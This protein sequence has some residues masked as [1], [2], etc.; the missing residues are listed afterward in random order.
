MALEEG[1]LWIPAGRW[2]LGCYRSSVAFS[3]HVWPSPRPICSLQKVSYSDCS[4]W[5][6]QRCLVPCIPSSLTLAP[7]LHGPWGAKSSAPLPCW[8]SWWAGL[9]AIA[10]WGSR[11][12]AQP[13]ENSPAAQPW[14]QNC[15]KQHWEWETRGLTI[16]HRQTVFFWLGFT[17]LCK[18]HITCLTLSSGSR[19]VLKECCQDDD[20]CS[21][22]RYFR[23]DWR[24]LSICWGS[25][26]GIRERPCVNLFL[27]KITLISITPVNLASKQCISGLCFCVSKHRIRCLCAGAWPQLNSQKT[28]RLIHFTRSTSSENTVQLGSGGCGRQP[29]EVRVL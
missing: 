7:I 22:L 11:V 17:L 29:G 13:H 6:L 20:A 12:E 10:S 8:K 14:V 21:F 25:C 2:S 27:I 24:A 28:N 3:G 26:L 5:V 16:E 19:L 4:L 18:F 23:S 9:H 1:G 15:W